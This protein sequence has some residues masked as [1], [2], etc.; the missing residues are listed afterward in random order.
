M[1]LI[2][3]RIV[4]PA[5][6]ADGVIEIEGGR[7]AGI[8]ADRG[9]GGKVK[10]FGKALLVPG[11]IDVHMHGMGG[12][13]GMTTDEIVGITQAE[14]QYGTTG[15]LITQG[16]LSVQDHL[17]FGRCVREAQGRAQG[18]GAKVLG[19]HFEGSFINP[20]R[21]GGFRPDC[22][23]P[24]D[25]QECQGYLD[26]LGDVLRLLTLSPELAGAEQ[27]IRMLSDAGVVVSLGHTIASKE[28]FL[29]AV[30]AGARLVCHLFDTFDLPPRAELG[31]WGVSLVEVALTTEQLCCEVICDLQHVAVE[32]VKLAAKALGPNR[33]IGITD[34]TSAAGYPVGEYPMADGRTFTTESGA[35]RLTAGQVNEGTLVGS[36]LTMNRAFGNLVDGCGIDL[37]SAGRFTATNAAELL[38]RADELGSIELG[39]AADIAVLDDNFECIATFVD[40]VQLYGD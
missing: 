14:L 9:G 2:K 36:V 30:K 35:A 29:A 10:D 26:E 39:K 25:V 8:S 20:E 5:G 15:F 21:R 3:G 27:A 32:H 38:G 24:V 1:S 6:V 18:R 37:V 7:I 11:F 31:V 16:G 34:S 19:A 12:Y 13:L 33:F 40:G 4:T 22:L 23:R 28:Q 17:D